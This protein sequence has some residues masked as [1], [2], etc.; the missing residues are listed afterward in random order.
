MIINQVAYRIKVG[1]WTSKQRIPFIEAELLQE[2][3]RPCF[4]EDI[5]II[6]ERE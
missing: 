3:L 5:I 1:N 6:A 4:Q 2:K